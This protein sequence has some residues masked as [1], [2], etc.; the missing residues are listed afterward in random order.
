MPH[1]NHT[2]DD[3]KLIVGATVIVAAPGLYGHVGH[4]DALRCVIVVAVWLDMT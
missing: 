4:T 3:C 2:N 1:N